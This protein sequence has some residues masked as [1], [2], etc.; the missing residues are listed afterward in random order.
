MIEIMRGQADATGLSFVEIFIQKC[1]NELV[2][3]YS[4]FSG[5][6]TSFAATGKATQ[7]GKTI[8]G[9]NIDFFPE[10]PI[11]LLKIHHASGLVQFIVNF[12]NS[13]EFTFSFA[14]LE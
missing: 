5:L 3:K 2:L 8:L 10:T 14:Q 1:S 4:D 6:C 13:S 12:S 11:D 9:Q 7:D